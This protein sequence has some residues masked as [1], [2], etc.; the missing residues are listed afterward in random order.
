ML[1][2]FMLRT[3]T[4]VSA[5]LVMILICATLMIAQGTTGSILGTVADSSGA[6]VPGV[7]VS[8]TNLATNLLRTAVTAPD[9]S[10]SITFLPVGTY[11][12]EIN[13]AGFKKFEQT[14][15]IL[16]INRN[17]RVDPVLQVGALTENGVGEFGC[18]VGK[19][20]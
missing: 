19:H 12:L 3:C 9:G 2:R 4:A 1:R 20:H 16:E 6:L 15:I 18:S 13:A 10:Y 17:A 8:V 14:G 11:L 5:A 7:T